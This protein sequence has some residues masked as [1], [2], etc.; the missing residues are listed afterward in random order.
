L[1]HTTTATAKGL[2]LPGYRR[3]PRVQLSLIR[4]E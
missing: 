3:L 4:H 2:I 1:G